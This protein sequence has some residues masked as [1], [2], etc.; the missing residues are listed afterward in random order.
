MK[1]L[2]KIT[3]LPLLLAGCV[4]GE[5]LPRDKFIEAEE[6]DCLEKFSPEKEKKNLP[7]NI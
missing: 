3:F 6:K 4:I 2:H 1:N 7:R 5:P